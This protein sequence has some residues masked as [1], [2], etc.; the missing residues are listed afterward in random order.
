MGQTTD[1]IAADIQDRRDALRSNFH[2]LENKAKSVTDWK[3]HFEKHPGI[4]VAAAI[5]A[6]ALVA[7]ISAGRKRRPARGMSSAEPRVSSSLPRKAIAR[8]GGALPAW[9]PIKGALI[10]LAVTRING[11]LEEMLPGF[12]EQLKKNGRV[13]DESSSPSGSPQDSGVPRNHNA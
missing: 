9:G 12:Q 13:K 11:F 2:E 4:M 3:Q 1:Q 8:A 10:G 7:T 6:G 5:G